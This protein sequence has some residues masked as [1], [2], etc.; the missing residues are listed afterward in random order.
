MQQV[1]E[2]VIKGVITLG[3]ILTV[4][5]Y[6]EHTQKYP[7]LMISVTAVALLLSNWIYYS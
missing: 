6:E 5:R 4:I 3:V 1:I 7:L 2:G